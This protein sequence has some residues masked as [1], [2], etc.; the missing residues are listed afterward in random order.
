MRGKKKKSKGP[1]EEADSIAN[2]R[3][4]KEV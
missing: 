1:K 2:I 4:K 3:I